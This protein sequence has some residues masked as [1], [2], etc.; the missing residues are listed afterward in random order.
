[1]VNVG[2]IGCGSITKYRH[3]PEFTSNPCARIIAFYD[4]RIERAMEMSDKYGG[5]VYEDYEAMLRDKSIDAVVVATPNRFHAPITIAALKAK[6]HVLCEK[7]MATTIEDGIKMI[8]A[9][10]TAEKFL[11]IDHNQRLEPVHIRAREILKSGELGNILSFKTTFGHGGP[12]SWSADNGLHTWFFKKQDAF[13]GS[14]GDLGIHKADLIRWL[15]DDE[16]TEV[17]AF[18]ATRD[19]K[20]DK[21]DLIEVDDNAVCILKSSS[22]IIGTLT[23]SWTYYND[24]DNSTVLYCSNGTMRI[25]DNPI[26]TIV[27]TKKNMENVFYQ[28]G[29]IQTNKNQVKSGVADLFIDGIIKGIQPRISGDEGLAALKIIAACMESSEKGCSVRIS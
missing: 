9:A 2:I 20:N 27:V 21:G 4:S 11:M 24:E 15:I 17:K 14:M 7:P 23:A 3:A 22:G 25:Y 29:S 6:K 16:I 12:E 18:V 26:Y 5:V 8:E 10:K 19:K 1:M 28:V 13:V